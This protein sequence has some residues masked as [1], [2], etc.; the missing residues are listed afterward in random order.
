MKVEIIFLMF[1]FQTKDINANINTTLLTEKL[2]IYLGLNQ[3]FVNFIEDENGVGRYALSDYDEY[4]YE[5]N[6]IRLVLLVSINSIYYS[7]N[8]VSV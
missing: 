8:N 2:A 5:A 3:K 4:R 6:L 7:P 1:I